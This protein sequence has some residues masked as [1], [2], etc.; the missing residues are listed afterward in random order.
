MSS[1]SDTPGRIHSVETFGALDGP[2]IRYVVFLQGCLLRCAY[3]HNPD[4]WDGCDGTSTTAGEAVEKILPYR[5]FIQSGGVT[6]SGGEPLMQP[7]FAAALLKLCKEQGLHTAIDT[8][9]AVPME[10]CREALELADM[11]LLDIKA[12]DSEECKSLTGMDN[13]NALRLLSWCEEVQ[14]PVWIRH[15][16][17]PGITLEPQKLEKLA[18]FLK[19]FSCI[20]KIE[21][22]PFHK[23]G[24][25]KWEVLKVPFILADTPEPTAA[26]MEEARSIFLAR[27]LPL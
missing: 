24:A 26:Q 3:C 5:N 12:L 25:Y 1:I 21:L 13:K 6:L 17:V 11:L 27:N 22:L 7:E 19:G 18:D 9:G 8:C 20:E 14:K 2:G 23:M 16:C 15:V 4:T 10:K